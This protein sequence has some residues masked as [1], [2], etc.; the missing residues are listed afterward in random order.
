[1]S[2]AFA[3]LDK[4]LVV[5]IDLGTTN[6]AVFQADPGSSGTNASRIRL[7][8]IPQ[9]TGPGEIH[10][11][12]V[13]PSF[14]Y[15]A[16]DFDVQ[17][18]SLRLPW[19]DARMAPDRMVGAWARDH[20]AHVPSRLVSSAKS[21]LC[22]AGVDRRAAILPWGATGAIPKVSPLEASA[23][24]LAHIR[25]AWNH[26]RPDD[27]DAHLEH[28]F[29]VLTVPASF[30][31][32]A[33]ELTLEA[34]HI[35][36]LG[37]VTLLEE[38][39]AAFYSYLNLHESDW[40]SHLQPGE[41]ILV[42]D[43]GGG[44]TDFSL[45]TLREAAGSPRFE[46]IAVGDHL[47]LGGDNIDL[48]LARMVEQQVGKQAANLSGDRWRT[49]CH[50]C[51]QAKE[52]LL[53]G[54]ADRKRITL[55][56]GGGKLIAGTMSAELSREAVEAVVL[57]GFFPLLDAS[58]PDVNRNR[59]G[60]TEFGLPYENEPAVT[61]H[62]GWFLEKHRRDV[63]QALG[64]TD[65][66]PDWILFNGGS[67]KPSL[68]QA[69]ICEAVCRW[70]GKDRQRTPRILVNPEPDLA[71]AMG[72][73]YYGLV[74]GGM[75]V[76]VG[77]GSARSYYLG[78]AVADSA[79]AA[80]ASP[81]KAVCI[82]ERGLEEGSPIRLPDREFRVLANSQ[83]IFP[84]YSSSFRS[85]D[86]TGDLLDIDE[87]FTRMPPLKTIIQYG[88]KGGQTTIPV[89]IDAEFTEM[90]TLAL[91][92]TSRLSE[93]RWKLQFQLRD[94]AAVALEVGE[95]EIFE[96]SLIRR[97]AAQI[98]AAFR[99]TPK[100][101]SRLVREIAK[102]VERP[103][104][105]WPLSL[106][107]HLADALIEVID[108]RKSTAEHEMRWLNLT[109]FCLR[110]GFGDA[111]DGQRLRNLWKLFKPGPVFSGQQQ[112]RIE[113][114]IFWRRIGAGLSPGQQRQILQDVSGL[115]LPGKSARSRMPVQEWLEL[116]MMTANLERLSVKDKVK[117]GRA[118]M[119]EI[120]S[121]KAYPQL[122]WGLS[123]IGAREL[124]YATA[125]RVVSPQEAWNWIEGCMQMPISPACLSC[126]QQLGRRTGDR[127][128]DIEAAQRQ[129]L[130]QWLEA[131]G[132]GPDGI[133]MVQ[134][135]TSIVRQDAQAIFGE[136]LPQGL[137]LSG[138]SSG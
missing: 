130:I 102:M 78:V 114:W 86:R 51:R 14:L 68:I 75:G 24:Y 94:P 121:G 30:D 118:L 26:L 72:A 13:L 101:L 105:Q 127:V 36:G 12:S 2:P 49:L 3:S 17:R 65:V 95:I 56:G 7:F 87:S 73:A 83:V 91:W 37:Q 61:R 135:P 81:E 58:A 97:A 50:Q 77:S 21:W 34:A 8:Q 33:R 54:A 35:A 90:G 71:V 74:K 48:A 136:A 125:D 93:H 15:L 92:C 113:W 133:R 128:R 88:K 132:V 22:H 112:V 126:V 76:R 70:F 32:V 84:I 69:R 85:G 18:D 40:S 129:R 116:W 64:R 119:A 11:L 99:G 31:E 42:C 47:I 53:E 9:L 131:N 96:E 108:T 25:S 46:R 104:E 107:R 16:G 66:V 6:S 138:E 110:P 79:S 59:A 106:I 28:Q 89:G 109:G 39:L 137:I 82:V 111:C 80:G 55:V 43:M 27:P 20:G 123:R 103:R 122:L 41:L 29:I 57:D 100:G 23:A 4:R 52:A 67:L 134:E 1:M 115:L 44:T 124:F 120:A 38:P 10:R 45:I 60:M 62:L 5:G 63:E 98:G 19:S 117:L